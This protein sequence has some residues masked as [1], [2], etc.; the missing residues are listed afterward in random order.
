M[1][2]I[3]RKPINVRGVQVSVAGQKVTYKGTSAAGVYEL[4]ETLKA[5]VKDSV[6]F[7]QPSSHGARSKEINR[8]WGLHRA[9]LSNCVQ[10]SRAPFEQQLEIVGLGFKAAVSGKKIQFSL[11][12]SHKI[13]FILP[14]G[15]SAETDKTGQL[16]TLRSPNRAQIGQAC[17]NI[18]ALRPPEP[19]KG[20]GVKLK[21]EIIFRKAGKTKSS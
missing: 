15:V 8:I 21:T 2:K 11:G 12:Y 16:L 20:T 10:G 19:Y 1:S 18:K 4:P 3:G 7:I 9:L 13:D 6:L 14:E 5:E 17:S